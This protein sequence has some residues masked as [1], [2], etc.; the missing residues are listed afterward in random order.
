MAYVLRVAEMQTTAGTASSNKYCKR[1]YCISTWRSLTVSLEMYMS[2]QLLGSAL[3]TLLFPNVVT[4]YRFRLRTNCRGEYFV[5]REWKLLKRVI[6]R[7][8][9]CMHISQPFQ[10]WNFEIFVKLNYRICKSE[11]T[12]GQ[13]SFGFDGA[14]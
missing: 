8:V 10:F 7:W 11:I 2:C 5:L 14:R 9:R 6:C 13:T 3:F 1:R 4:R 12:V